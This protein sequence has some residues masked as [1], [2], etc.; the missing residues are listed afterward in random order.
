MFSAFFWLTLT[1]FFFFFFSTCFAVYADG[2]I[3]LDILQNQWSPIYDVAAILTSIQVLLKLPYQH[4]ALPWKLGITLFLTDP[5]SF[6]F[7]YSH[8]LQIRKPLGF[9][10]KT[11]VSTTEKCVML[12]SKAGLRLVVVRVVSCVTLLSYLNVFH[13]CILC[14]VFQNSTDWMLWWLYETFVPNLC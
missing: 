5:L 4:L 6:I 10:A 13:S 8:L 3:C 2:S 7:N 11:S 1:F 14:C 9:T 12:S